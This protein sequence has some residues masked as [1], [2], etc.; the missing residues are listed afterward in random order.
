[1]QQM[2]QPA[3][4]QQAAVPQH[5][6]AHSNGTLSV[7]S[8]SIIG[9]RMVHTPASCWKGSARPP[10]RQRIFD[11]VAQSDGLRHPRAAALADIDARVVDAA[12]CQRHSGLEQ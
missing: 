11:A 2:P 12:R 5:F 3:D 10:C 7:L 1:M 9:T 8:A 4:S 6:P